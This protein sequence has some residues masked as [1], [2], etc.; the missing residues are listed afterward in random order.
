MKIFRTVGTVLLGTSFAQSENEQNYEWRMGYGEPG[1]EKWR[2]FD[3]GYQMARTLTDQTFF[4]S[5][6]KMINQQEEC[7]NFIENVL[8]SPHG[9]RLKTPKTSLYNSNL[10]I[11]GIMLA[12]WSALSHQANVTFRCLD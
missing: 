3:M 10:D 4:K 1:K 2:N 9:Q 5:Q 7:I 8:S 12:S 6:M 11:W